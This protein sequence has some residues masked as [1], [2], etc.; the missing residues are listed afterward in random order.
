MKFTYSKSG[1]EIL[2]EQQE[3]NNYNE[4]PEVIEEALFNTGLSL[5][6]IRK[7]RKEKPDEY[8]NNADLKK[9]IDKYGDDLEKAA[10]AVEE[11]SDKALKNWLLGLIPLVGGWILCLSPLWPVGVVLE[12]LSIVFDIVFITVYTKDQS[13]VKDLNKI[14]DALVKQRKNKKWPASVDKKMASIIDKIDNA[15]A[16]YEQR[17]RKVE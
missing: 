17:T 11:N 1:A 5:K 7:M 13:K 14:R 8:T 16:D 12:V 4:T 3:M 2:K 9:F 15:S 10:E 6:Y